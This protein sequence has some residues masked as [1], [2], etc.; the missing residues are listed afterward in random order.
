MMPESPPK[1]EREVEGCA[2]LTGS[3]VV[4]V[5]SLIRLAEDLEAWAAARF[6]E[7]KLARKEGRE[8]PYHIDNHYCACGQED[9]AQRIRDLIREESFCENS[10]SPKTRHDNS[11]T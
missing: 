2:A 9:A 6:E 4:A 1:T 10:Y 5:S 7:R 3:R 8:K 11:E